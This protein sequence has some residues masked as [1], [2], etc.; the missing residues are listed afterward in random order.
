MLRTCSEWR[1]IDIKRSQTGASS[2]ACLARAA[3][4]SSSSTTT[5]RSI[6]YSRRRISRNSRTS[7]LFRQTVSLLIDC[8]MNMC[9][10]IGLDDCRA[11]MPR[12]RPA[13]PLFSLCA[14]DS[15]FIRPHISQYDVD[16]VYCHRLR[17]VVCRSVTIVI[18]AKTA[19]PIEMPFGLWTRMGPRNHA[20]HGGSDLCVGRSNFGGRD[21]TL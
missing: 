4:A 10:V 8:N 17:S 15:L 9:N 2:C 21:G 3:I 20:L 6:I 14:W 1:R 19:E 13:V 5:R 7:D 18:P 16:A 12:L 11:H